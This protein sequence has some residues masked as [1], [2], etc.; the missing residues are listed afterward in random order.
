MPFDDQVDVGIVVALEREISLFLF[1]HPEHE[2]QSGKQAVFL[3]TEVGEKVVGIAITGPGQERAE[4]GTRA[5]CEAM[6]PRW[7][8][9]A[10][11]GGALLPQ[12]KVGDAVFIEDI[13]TSNDLHVQLGGNYAFADSTDSDKFSQQ[14]NGERL[15]AMR[16]RLFSGDDM[17]TTKE[18][19]SLLAEKHNADVVD[20]ETAAVVKVAREW[21]LP[22]LALR[23]ITDDLETEL[24]PEIASMLEKEG[25]SRWGTIATSLWKKPRLSK[26]LWELKQNSLAAS[27]TIAIGVEYLISNLPPSTIKSTEPP[28]DD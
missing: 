1:R 5:L 25:A 2:R 22:V 19:R 3:Q 24:P 26:N 28:S 15:R 18:E 7:I 10:G 4:A 16:G 14:I 13:V 21:H 23:A 9:S 6:H 17:V 8:I 12:Q 27:E 11:Y 20:M